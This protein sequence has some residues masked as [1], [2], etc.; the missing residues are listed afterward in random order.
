MT[1]CISA[2]GVAFQRSTDDGVTYQTLAEITDCN[3][4][5]S[6]DELDMTS[7]DTP[8][9]WRERGPGLL[10]MSITVDLNFVPGNA[11]HNGTAG[12]LSD[13]YNRVKRKYK[14][15]TASG[16]TL[17][18]GLKLMISNASIGLAT[19]AKESMSLTFMNDGPPAAVA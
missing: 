11:G 9:P 4:D 19:D 12:V 17:I 15:T 18:T 14:L 16:V 10:S 5:M 8:G 13:F 6:A 3:V 7:H 2:K 1:D